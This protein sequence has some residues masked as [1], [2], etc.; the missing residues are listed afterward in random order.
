MRLKRGRDLL[1]VSYERAR[2]G[3]RPFQRL[4]R[5]VRKREEISQV[6]KEKSLPLLGKK[7]SDYL[8]IIDAYYVLKG[9][10]EE[11][12]VGGEREETKRK[13]AKS[14]RSP[15]HD[16]TPCVRYVTHRTADY[17]TS[18]IRTRPTFLPDQASMT[19][20]PPRSRFFL[21]VMLMI[22][23][24]T[25]TLCSLWRRQAPPK[26]CGIQKE[27]YMPR[28]WISNGLFIH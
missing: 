11:G 25:M 28:D 15:L 18:H 8:H 5:L 16:V 4:Q 6:K 23:F 10:K 13:K 1:G 7:G 12:E 20:I 27:K 3:I 2:G 9:E 26:E 24:A 17:R 14:R 21:R 19:R 22:L